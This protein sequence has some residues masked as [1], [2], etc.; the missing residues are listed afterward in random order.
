MRSRNKPRRGGVV[1][2]AI[3]V[4]ANEATY[5]EFL[6]RF[7]VSFETVRDP[8]WDLSSRFGTFQ[9]PETYVIDRFGKV[10]VKLV[11]AHDF[12]DPGFLAGIGRLL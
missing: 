1:V 12:M 7:P 10:V 6:R 11:G 8:E 2:L 5:Q 3:S 9:L 4:D